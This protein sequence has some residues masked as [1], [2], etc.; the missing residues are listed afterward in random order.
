MKS[1]SYFF[2]GHISVVFGRLWDLSQGL[3]FGG[4]DIHNSIRGPMLILCLMVV[5]LCDANAFWCNIFES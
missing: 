5:V 4:E 2:V 3:V 1:G